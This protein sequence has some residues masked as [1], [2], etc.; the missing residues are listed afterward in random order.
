M[1]YAEEMGL[2]ISWN[3]PSATTSKL[4]VISQIPRE[5]D[6]PDIP[7][8]AWFH[9]AGPFHDGEGRTPIAFPWEKLS[10]EPLIYAS[11][12]T[13]VNGLEHVHKAILGAVGPLTGFQIVLSIGKFINPADL[14]PIPANTLLV[15]EAPQIELLKIAALCITHAG[16][17]TVLETLAQGVPMVAIPNSYDQPGLP[18]A[19]RTTES[20][21]S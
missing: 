6:Y 19:F 16:L 18:L 20:G 9:Y 21:S 8:P 10:G 4:A 5:F 1:P 15:A 17:N 14:G 3:D 7:W 12:G 11:L 2:D 13:V